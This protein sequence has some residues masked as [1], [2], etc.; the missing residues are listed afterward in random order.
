MKIQSGDVRRA[1]RLAA[2]TALIGIAMSSTSVRAADLFTVTVTTGGETE[3]RSFS[4]AEEALRIAEQENLEDLF[5]NYRE[6]DRVTAAIDFRG[7]PIAA[8]F[9]GG[10]SAPTLVFKVE[11]LGIEET[12]DGATRDQSVNQ[13]VDF[14][15]SEGKDV[16]DRIQ[17]TL[18]AVSPVDPIAGNPGS[19]QSMMVRAAFDAGAF[20]GDP[21]RPADGFS[22]G[23]SGS[24][25]KT[26][27]FSGRGVTLPMSYSFEF[28][29]GAGPEV[30][31]GLS[32][33]WQSVSGAAVYAA[34]PSVAFTFPVNDSWALTP[35]VF[36]GATGSADAASV[37]QMVGASLVS[38]YEI[39]HSIL[40]GTKLVLGNMV[41]RI[42]T[43]PFSV[44][45]YS[46]DPGIG[47]TVLKNGLAVE[48]GTGAMLS[49]DDELVV[50]LSYAHSYFMGTEL[51]LN[52]YHEVALGVGS[53]DAK[54]RPVADEMR[55]DAV[56][57]FGDSYSKFGARFV[58]RF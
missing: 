36:Y 10:E 11:S 47:N 27:T 3:T 28:D 41:G 58:Y 45:G 16:L 34:S 56:Y 18:A 50:R 6:T 38:R 55:F 13:F 37:A 44:Q 22:A 1:G 9:S 30:E 24:A 42:S 21:T 39:P 31:I 23:V 25:F 29:D 53:A 8:E 17:K 46:F 2:L 40:P 26:G 32:L 35:S 57:T 49:E 48:R 12:F 4:T 7:L 33:R 19:L 14:L 54:G 15:K 51:F 20:G 5:P 52:Q 43:L